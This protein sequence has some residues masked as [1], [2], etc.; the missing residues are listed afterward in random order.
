MAMIKITLPDSSV[1]QVEKGATA[2]QVAETIGPRLAKDAYAA[3]ADGILIDMSRKLEKDCKLRIITQKDKEGIEVLRHSSAHVLAEA[4]LSLFPDAKPTIGPVVEEGFYYDFDYR[5]FTSDDLSRIEECMREIIS[6]KL[7][8]ERVE[9]SKD[10]ALKMFAENRYKTEMIREIGSEEIITAYKQGNFIDLCRG[11][12]LPDTGKIAAFKLTKLAGAYWRGDAKNQQLQRIYGISFPN[13]EQLADHLKRLEEAEKRDHKKIGKDQELFMISDMIGKGLPVW[14][15]RGNMIKQEIERFAVETEDNAGYLR[16]STPHLAKEELF[17]RSGHLPHYKESMYPPMVMDDG[18]YYLKAMN[19]PMHHLVFGYRPRSYRE[20]PLRIAEYGT[21]YRNELS[22]ALSGLLR[23]RMLSMNDAHIYCTA[24]QVESEIASVI[25]MV[26]DY[27]SVFGFI[28]YHFRLSLG[29]PGNKEKFIDEP[30]NWN[31]TQETLRKV[32]KKLNCNFVEASGEA[33]F[34][35]PKIDIQFKTVLGREETMSTIQLDF[36]AKKRFELTYADEKGAINHEVMVIHRA[37]LS[38]H[39]RFTAFV[40]EHFA[41]RFPLWL[42]PAQA[43]VLTVADRHIPHAE[44]MLKKL[45]EAGIRAET[46]FLA[47]TIPKKVRD[48]QLANINYI[49]VIGDKETENSTVNVRTRDNI[50]HG[51]KNIDILIR[52]MQSEIR[53]RKNV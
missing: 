26:Q 3:A 19:C 14:L 7:S 44:A 52:E 45:N 12:H 48:A 1:K 6:K 40:I 17:L 32:L 47:K 33:A 53:N 22:G 15:P 23:V 5:P 24:E 42:S 31:F 38:T 34:Y 11:P 30:E 25:R 39:E 41:G 29:D 49:L 36:A 50:V 4:V 10:E 18:T 51:E 35:G 46:D 16:V 2:L 20:L 9:L 27:Y 43:I 28:D 13:K 37:P 8:F 21:V